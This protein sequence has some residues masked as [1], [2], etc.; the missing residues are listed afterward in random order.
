M[1]TE[2]RSER[3]VLALL[4]AGVVVTLRAHHEGSR[5]VGTWSEHEVSR[6]TQVALDG[7]DGVH[8]SVNLYAML[9]SML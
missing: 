5:P 7:R 2:V 3:A 1:R 9:S 6:L 8:L 4:G